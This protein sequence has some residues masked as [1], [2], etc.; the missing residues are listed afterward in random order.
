[1]G[2]G[3]K[4]TSHTEYESTQWQFILRFLIGNRIEETYI[5]YYVQLP[6][7][8]VIEY[9][10]DKSHDRLIECVFPNLKENY[11]SISYTRERATLSTTNEHV[12]T[13]NG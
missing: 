1:M 11:T 7:D 2:Q 13:L 9:S 8:I 10:C 3:M 12:D 4:D 5:D 6:D